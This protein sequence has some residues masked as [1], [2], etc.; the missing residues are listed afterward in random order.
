MKKLL[1]VIALFTSFFVNAQE[2]NKQVVINLLEKNKERIREKKFG[3][4]SAP[5]SIRFS[6]RIF[7]KKFLF[8]FFKIVAN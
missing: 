7:S 1:V 4:C 3:T 5:S 2:L 8:L 6:S